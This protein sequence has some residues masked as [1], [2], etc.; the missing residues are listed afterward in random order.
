MPALHAVAENWPSGTTRESYVE[1]LR[2]LVD[3][4]VARFGDADR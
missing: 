1:G 2:V 4:Y 3:G